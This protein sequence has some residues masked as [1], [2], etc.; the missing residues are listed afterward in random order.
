MT[1][2]EDSGMPR[3]GRAPWVSAAAMTPAQREFADDVRSGWSGGTVGLEPFDR[4]GRLVGPF[5]LMAASP[6]VGRQILAVAESFRKSSLTIAE[7]ELVIVLVAAEQGSEFMWRG[8]VPLLAAAGVEEKAT[9]S[10]REHEKPDLPGTLADVYDAA[11]ALIHDG[12]LDDGHFR[13]A[14][15][16]LG[17]TKLQEVVWLV[18]LYWTLALAMRVARVP[19]PD[20][21]Q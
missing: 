2:T 21:P 9:A 14:E 20:D 12:D 5:D 4:H 17:W 19:I 13:D 6:D 3:L 7:R 11:W 1:D 8:H 16:S 15:S 10:I 18:G